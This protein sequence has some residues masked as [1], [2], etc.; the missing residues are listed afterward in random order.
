MA[1]GSAGRHPAAARDEPGVG[2][3]EVPHITR[4]LRAGQICAAA[5]RLA[6]R[7]RVLDWRG[8]QVGIGFASTTGSC[9]GF[10][11]GGR[12]SARETAREPGVAARPRRA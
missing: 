1:G 5:E 8:E 12:E 4:I 9:G 7:R 3:A 10:G 6:V 2:E 11:T